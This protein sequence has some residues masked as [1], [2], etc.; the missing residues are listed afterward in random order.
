MPHPETTFYN[1]R[2]RFH[3]LLFLIGTVTLLLMLMLILGVVVLLLWMS[4][5]KIIAISW[6]VVW[7]MKIS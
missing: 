3:C 6:I 7:L 4:H 1:G 2:G 5:F